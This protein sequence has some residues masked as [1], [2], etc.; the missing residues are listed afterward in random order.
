MQYEYLATRGSLGESP[1][2]G[3]GPAPPP[4][5]RPAPSPSRSASPPPKRNASGAQ[6]V[7]HLARNDPNT[8]AVLVPSEVAFRHEVVPLTQDGETIVLGALDPENIAKADRLSSILARPVRLKQLDRQ[9]LARLQSIVYS[10]GSIRARKSSA[11]VAAA[12]ASAGD[13]DDDFVDSMLQE[14][15]GD[16]AIHPV[17][18]RERPAPPMMARH[19]PSP[20]F[21]SF[22][23]PGSAD[24]NGNS[25]GSTGMFTF[26]VEEGQRVLM[27]RPNGT[28]DVV[29]GPR[30][31]W[32]GRNQFRAMIHHVAHPGD[33]LI[34]RFRDG[35]Q[36]HL[37][38]PAEVWFDPR[39]HE[40]VEV[41]EA[42]QIAA[43]EAVVV[44]SQKEGTGNVQRRIEYG[45]ALF[46][47][48][49]GEWLH[50]F[51]WHASKGG[52]EGVVKIP[53]GLV[54]QKLWLMPDQM[55]HDVSDVRTS[56]DAVL[57]IRLMIF[58]ELIDIDRMLDAT[59]DPIGDFVNAASSDV[60][61]FTGRH[62]F[63]SFKRNTERL[64]ELDA[65]RQLTGRAAQCGYRINKVV[66][67]GYGA[68]DRLQQ[69]HDQAIEARTRLQLDRATEQQ[70]Q[71][72]ENFKLDSQLARAGKRRVEQA[73]EVSHELELDARRLDAALKADDARRAA[74]REAARLDAE[75]NR[76]ALALDDAHRRDHLA[77]LRDL[78]VD[79]T[80][81]LTQGRADRVI[82]LRSPLG[83]NGSTHVHL[84]P[85]SP[86]SPRSI[87]P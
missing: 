30:R 78:G 26:V 32:R 34:V 58:F 8:L 36:E 43:K 6:T 60:V 35:R 42:L 82:E 37:P 10:S 12:P 50:T 21:T 54:F 5:P 57:R 51:S 39:S 25:G 17:T 75:Q 80:A 7:S 76:S 62:D 74:H 46:M 33:Y 4:P 63:E 19:A 55:Y 20:Y 53:N 85:S 14:F 18:V 86:G 44:Y 2:R 87:A 1:G 16:T 15:P 84:D 38:G 31:V 41:R 73:A 48:R 40:S 79:L 77:S 47:P 72:L 83:S 22:S 56:D 67:R 61:D 59:H 81:F 24:S 28:M 71:D 27:R 49:P 11:A 64:N 68:A 45:P 52:S 13:F 3:R 29:V 23:D 70:E 69:M 66:Y 9:S 65:Y